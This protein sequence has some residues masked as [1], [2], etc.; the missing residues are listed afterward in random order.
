MF[1]VNDKVMYKANTECVVVKVDHYEGVYYTI[2]TLDNTREIQTV[3]KHLSPMGVS[4]GLSDLDSA[5]NSFKKSV[6]ELKVSFDNYEV[7]SNK[8]H[9]ERVERNVRRMQRSFKR[10]ME[11]KYRQA[12]KRQAPRRSRPIVYVIQT[13]VVQTPVIPP[14]PVVIQA[15]AP[16]IPPRPVV[17]QAQAPAIPARPVY[18]DLQ[19]NLCSGT[20]VELIDRKKFN[21][22]KT[23]VKRKCT[24]C[25]GKKRLEVNEETML[26]ATKK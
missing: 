15:Q 4:V 16:V 3:E 6:E 11:A 7:E 5:M 13:P 22:I 18:Y 2:Q 8:R 24:M 26:Y 12:P 20:G 25:G 19:C 14:R 17:I 21:L 23:V 10:E 1:Q 9:E